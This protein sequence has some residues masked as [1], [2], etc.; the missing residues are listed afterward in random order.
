MKSFKSL[1]LVFAAAV[2]SLGSFA[3]TSTTK[4]AAKSDAKK[5]E[6]AKPAAKT[7]AKT[8]TKSTAKTTAKKT[9]AA[10]K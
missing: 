10:K 2:I 3:Q 9:D 8:E 6:A 5:T 7:A 1:A 4:P